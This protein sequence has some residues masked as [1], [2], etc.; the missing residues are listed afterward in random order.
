MPIN[1]AIIIGGGIAG[2]ACAL[3]LIKHNHISC[4]IFEIRS[5]PSTIGGAVNLTPNALRYLEH[6]GV[7]SRLKPEGCEV[8]YI[9]VISER[10]GQRLG[11]IDFDNLP[12]F[13]HHGLRVMRYELL[14]ALLETLKEAGVEVQYGKTIQSTSEEHKRITANFDDGTTIE[15]DILLGCDGIH[16][17]IRT[18]F[19]QPDRKPIYSG[20]AVAYGFLNVGDLR[21]TLQVDSTSLFSGRFGSLLMSYTDAAKSRLYLSAVMETKDP[22]S[23]EGWAVK[24]NDQEPLKKDL[25]RRFS[26]GTL[27]TFDQVV[28]KL[29]SLLLY[30]VY[31]LSA[32]GIWSSGR[33]MLLGDAAHAMPP[34]GESVGL[35]LED[36][37]LFSRIVEH[38]ETRSVAELFSRYEQLRRPRI[39]AAV[40]EANFGWET[41]KDRGWFTTVVLEWLTWVIL[42]W[43]AKRKEE[44]FEFDVRDVKLG[45]E[46]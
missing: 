28:A 32:S 27:S 20:I 9:D 21:D 33:M 23:R 29:D 16:S 44:E 15:G 2:V 18:K 12:K 24:G 41:I 13:K 1:H 17:A 34:Q 26:G 25:L 11:I 4:S 10:T 5:E 42:A 46:D 19:I 14:E 30:P 43:R 35:A 8:K 22:G 39:D 38:S 6:L 31:R 36:V 7:L 3:A 45:F 40:K 37:V